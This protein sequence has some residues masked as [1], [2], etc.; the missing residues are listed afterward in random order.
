[1]KKIVL[2]MAG[3]IA[4]QMTALATWRPSDA[5]LRAVRQVESN[6]GRE[7]YGDGGRSLGAFQISEA[8]WVDVSAYRKARGQKVYSYDRHVMHGYI[9]QVYAADYLTMIHSEL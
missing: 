8:A 7:L 6:N 3:L 1:M 9:N 4:C 2:I 5:L